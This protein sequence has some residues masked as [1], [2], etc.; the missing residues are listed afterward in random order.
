MKTAAWH[1]WLP[2]FGAAAALSAGFAAAGSLAGVSPLG[3]ALAGIAVL[4]ATLGLGVAAAD[5]LVPA[6]S[7]MSLRPSRPD[8]RPS[9]RQAIRRRATA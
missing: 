2:S 8:C 6:R 1:P 5:L 4:G 3:A 9:P 7:P